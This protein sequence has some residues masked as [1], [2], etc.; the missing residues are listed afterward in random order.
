MAIAFRDAC[1]FVITFGKKYPGQTVARIGAS[2]QGLKDLDWY[3]DQLWL[4]PDAKE[5]IGTYLKNPAIAQRLDSLL[6]D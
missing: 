4:F 3:L 1:D 6:D 5:A 2:D